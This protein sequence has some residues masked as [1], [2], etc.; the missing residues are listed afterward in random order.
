M[1]LYSNRDNPA[2]NN[3]LVK[4]HLIIV[5]VKDLVAS[6]E[7]AWAWMRNDLADKEAPRGISFISG[8]SST[9]DI[10]GHLVRGAH[11]PQRL[12]VILLGEVP[13][14]LLEQALERAASTKA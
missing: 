10:I 2:S 4:D 7:D 11:G 8:P 1:V 12:R 3:W 13:E 14:R 5:E 6:Y 9:G